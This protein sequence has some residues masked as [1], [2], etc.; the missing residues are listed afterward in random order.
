MSENALFKAIDPS[1]IVCT[2]V[3]RNKNRSALCVA[4][5]IGGASTKPKA[6]FR[7]VFGLHDL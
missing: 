1:K 7:F 5:K 4:A 3:P 6:S 2:F